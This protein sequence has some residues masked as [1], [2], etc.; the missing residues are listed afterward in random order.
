MT[1]ILKRNRE[2]RRKKG[3]KGGKEEGGREREAKE[4]KVSSLFREDF[5]F[6]VATFPNLD[7][8]K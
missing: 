4:I 5:L 1:V 2:T 6:P 8:A 7:H 3:K